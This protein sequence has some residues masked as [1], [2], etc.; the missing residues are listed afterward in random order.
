ME[1][2][3]SRGGPHRRLTPAAGRDERTNEMANDS[4]PIKQKTGQG[5][6]LSEIEKLLGLIAGGAISQAMSVAAELGVADLLAGG[7]KTLD[8]LAVATASHPLSVHRL[9][10]ALASADLCKETEDGSF[11]LTPTGSLLRSDAADSFRSHAIWWGRYRWPVWGNLLHSVRT[12]ESA[13][14]PVSRT[15]GMRQLN[16]DPQAAGIF[17]RAMA[18]LTRVVAQGMVRSY[19]FAG[20][21]RVV[22]VGGGYGEL[23]TAILVAHPAMHGVLF[24]QPH[25]IEGAR[26]HLERAGVLGRCDIVTGDFFKSVPSGGD[27][28]L[29]KTVIHDW[30]DEQSGV[31]LQNCRRAVAQRGKLLLV[32]QIMPKRITA[33]FRN[34]RAAVRDLNML[35]MLGGR[36]R[37]ASDFRR[38]LEAAGFRVTNTTNAALD[39][40]TI[41][42]IPA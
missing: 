3:G 8:E 20:M 36:E 19:D 14:G 18:E 28:Y 41:E 9:M 40:S 4:S 34:Q 2:S 11:A 22:D 37:T 26:E 27:G 1:Q 7:P 32:E 23:L 30:N 6:D 17:H 13:G 38:L 5:E 33:S 24:D 10:R 29:L 39:Y 15:V 42:A 12:G 31:I 16:G 21:K 25:A 35:V